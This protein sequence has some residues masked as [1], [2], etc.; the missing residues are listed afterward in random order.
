MSQSDFLFE[1][2]PAGLP[3]SLPIFPLAGVLLLPR[4]RLPLN[5]F[6]PRYI[7]MVEDALKGQRMV[8]MVQ[9]TSPGIAGKP[10]EV[11]AT[12]CAGRI[13]SFSETDD[14][15]YLITLAG[16]S[17]F[18]IADELEKQRGYRRVVADWKPFAVDLDPSAGP[19]LDRPHLTPLLKTY[20]QHQGLSADWDAISSTPDDRLLTSLAMICPFEPMEKQALL[21]APDNTARAKVMVKLLEMAIASG[22][23]RGSAH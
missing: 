11:F 20:F 9:P 3:Q 12:G 10:C 13:V 4:G 15:R 21:E 23:E 14:G 16:V 22:S 17:R 2:G 18:H 6:E 5:I 1:P 7:A 8:G 19:T